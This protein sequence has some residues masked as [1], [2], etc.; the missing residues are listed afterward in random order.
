MIAVYRDYTNGP[1]CRPLS[2]LDH[3]PFFEG[4]ISFSPPFQS[5]FLSVQFALSLVLPFLPSS[6]LENQ[7]LLVAHCKKVGL[8]T[9]F[10]TLV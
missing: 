6:N 2:F 9:V 10:K 1:Y 7:L 5:V 8:F 4:R 3:Y